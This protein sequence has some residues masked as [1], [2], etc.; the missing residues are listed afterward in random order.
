MPST[1]NRSQ[2][3]SLPVSKSSPSILHKA[4]SVT[5]LCLLSGSTLISAA[6]LAQDTTIQDRTSSVK[7]MDA[8]V[9]TA[10]G[11]EQKLTDAPASITVITDAELRSRPF[12]NLL[13]AM[14]DVEGIDLGTGQDKSG[15]GSISMRG[16]GSDYTLVLINGKRQNNNGD[17]YPNNFGGFQSA[18]IPPIDMIERIE[19]VRGP[20]STLYGADAM[21]G[22]INIITK[23][24]SDK[25]VGS[26][27]HGRTFQENSDLGN[28]TT[29]DF[30]VAGPLIKDLLGLSV[31]GSVYDKEEST[32]EYDATIDPDGVAYQPETGFG[33][34]GKTSDNKNYNTGFG[35]VFTPDARNE[36]IFDYDISRQEYD[37]SEAQFGTLDSAETILARARVGY[38]ATQHTSRTQWSLGHIG[39]WDF[40][41]S[42]ITLTHIDTKNNGRSLPLSL[43]QRLELR[44]RIA[45]GALTEA[46][47]L[48]WIESN[49]LPRPNRDL[50]SKGYTLDAKLELPLGD[51]FVVVGGQ[52][53]DQEMT[54]GVFSMTGS[55]YSGSSKQDYDQYSVFAEDSWSITQDLTL[56][57]G[58][59]YD[60]N[61]EFG[62][63]TS[64]RIYAVYNVSTDWTV[65]GGVSTG[66]KTPKTS[67]LYAGITGFGGQGTSPWVGNPDLKPETSVSGELATYFTSLDGH[68]FNATLFMTQ[69]KDK[70]QNIDNCQ[71]N[72]S[73]SEACSNIGSEWT[74]TVADGG[75]NYSINYKGNVSEAEIK[76][77]EL[78]ARYLLP[79][80]FSIKAN[81]T[82]TE[83]EITKGPAKG[84]P[85]T[86]NPTSASSSSAD[87]P[88]QHM[89]NVSLNWQANQD[90]DL[91]VGMYAEADRV[92]GWDED[93]FY[94]DYKDYQIFHLGG[95]FAVSETLTVSARINNLFDR[96][97]TSYDIDWEDNAGTWEAT[98]LDDYKVIDKSR[99]L[100]VSANMR[101]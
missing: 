25:W 2:Y 58:I 1:T 61:A 47:N 49:L 48:S 54:D 11:Y 59:R 81:Y 30:A 65:K 91:Y 67:D 77:V 51:H 7:N 45:D 87:T 34:A 88:A 16:L 20:M 12:T 95:N 73:G 76:G 55:G 28:D 32:P 50:S 36:I 42:D 101:F 23:S 69:F 78:A 26:I 53:I 80:N 35:L 89:A 100:W 66:Y 40:G 60:D 33:G 82:Y 37:N 31:R 70:I 8:V 64:P 24:I 46:D 41:R 13:D 98:Q 75:L 3:H 86:G 22:V 92:R 63:H 15:Q 72:P 9:V 52:I 4:S 27:T 62:G 94:P 97:F 71:D 18:N 5:K 96:D 57:G 21:G 38:E 17:I 85:L 6:T 14:R 99:N 74:E 10:A 90:I 39:K 93:G 56:T 84:R 19:V 79:N 68:T 29:T 44:D 43:E 83:S